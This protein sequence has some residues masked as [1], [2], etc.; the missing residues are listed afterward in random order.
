MAENRC[1]ITQPYIF[2]PESN[3]GAAEVESPAR[4]Q[5]Q[6]LNCLS[7]Q[8]NTSYTAVKTIWPAPLGLL[9]YRAVPANWV[10]ILES[11]ET[12]PKNNSLPENDSM[13]FLVFGLFL[14][15]VESQME[16][17]KKCPENTFWIIVSPLGPKIMKSN[18]LWLSTFICHLSG[19]RSWSSKDTQLAALPQRS[20]WCSPSTES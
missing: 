11:F 8:Q 16:V 15:G 5:Q 2:G 17:P 7:Q 3:P 4:M 10:N 13:F 1:I 20:V 12:S 9:G 19:W 18:I 14:E 6:F